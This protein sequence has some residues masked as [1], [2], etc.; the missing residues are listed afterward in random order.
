MTREAWYFANARPFWRAFWKRERRSKDV[1]ASSLDVF[2]HV[3]SATSHQRTRVPKS[4]VLN[5]N[6]VP[7]LL[8]HYSLVVLRRIAAKEISH[9]GAGQMLRRMSNM[10]LNYGEPEKRRAPFSFFPWRSFPTGLRFWKRAWI[11]LAASPGRA[12]YKEHLLTI[13]LYLFVLDICDCQ[14]VGQGSQ[15]AGQIHQFSGSAK[16]NAWEQDWPS[17]G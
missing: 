8:L 15:A 10:I 17:R 2:I 4:K 13:S 9:C 14:L 16:R 5:P 3:S 1:N 6:R 7:L 11:E 12:V